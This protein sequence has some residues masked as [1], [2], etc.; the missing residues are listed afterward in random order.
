V[1]GGWE[2]SGITRAQSGQYLTATGN[3]SIGARRADYVEGQDIA[4]DDGDE[5]RWFNTAAFVAAPNTRRGTATVGQIQGPAYYVWDVSFRK[6][7]SVTQDVK[8]GVQADI[9]NLFNRVNLGNPNTVTTDGNYGRINA[10]A[11]PARQM[12]IGVRLEF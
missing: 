9:F 4:I 12:Q 1:L 11:G 2:A 6:K 10:T 7:F 5:N 8:V 3:T